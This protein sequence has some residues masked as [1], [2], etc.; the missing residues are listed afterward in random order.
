MP[1]ESNLEADLRAIAAVNQQDVQF[2]LANNSAGMMS[3]WTDD[4]VL[5][6]AAGPIQ[7]GRSAIAEASRGMEN[8]VEIL[9]YVLDIQEVKVLGDHAFQW[10]TYRYRMRPRAGGEEVRVG[11][12]LMRIL[13]RQPDGS[14]K[15]HRGMT[16]ND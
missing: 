12:K 14:W 15:I 5:L 13:Q 2:A 1:I 11:G 7:R 6:P 16:T 4:I 8:T 10:G 3:Q 9:E